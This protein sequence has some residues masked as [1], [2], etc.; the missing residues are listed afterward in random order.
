M[1]YKTVY[2]FGR[3][4]IRFNYTPVRP[5][6]IT[7]VKRLQHEVASQDLVVHDLK[8]KCNELEKEVAQLKLALCVAKIKKE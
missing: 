6:Q 8:V 4:L 7:D 1:V 2:R 3:W 5:V